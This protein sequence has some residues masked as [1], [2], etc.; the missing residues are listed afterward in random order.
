LMA[1]KLS[2]TLGLAVG[3]SSGAN[4]I[5]A[6]K[7]QNMLGGDK[8]VV[9]IF[10][11]SNKKYLST[12]LMKNEPVKSEHLTPHIELNDFRALERL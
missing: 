7:V 11:D 9:T 6:V 12:D 4:F 5:G 8:N 1:Q 3:I 10:C 2:R